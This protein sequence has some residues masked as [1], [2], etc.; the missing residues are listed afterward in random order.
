MRSTKLNPYRAPGEKTRSQPEPLISA[1]VTMI[2][3]I[4]L[5]MFHPL[6]VSL[7]LRT[8]VW[9]GPA[10]AFFIIAGM[11]FAAV[12]IAARWVSVGSCICLL[13]LALLLYGFVWPL[14]PNGLPWIVGNDS[15][16]PIL[17]IQGIASLVGIAM[18]HQRGLD[19]RR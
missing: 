8:F 13:A 2:F 9:Q 14:T 1:G 3:F 7:L 5:S 4:V 16:V 18:A 15:P 10:A 6:M 17:I 11:C 19:V 12:V